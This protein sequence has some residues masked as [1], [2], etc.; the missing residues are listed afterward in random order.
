MAGFLADL[1]LRFLVGFVYFVINALILRE[2][3]VRLFKIAD[4]TFE[5]P[6]V[7][8][9]AISF[10]VILFSYFSYLVLLSWLLMVLINLA[11]IA[12]VRK[13]YNLLWSNAIHIWGVWFIINIFIGFLVVLIF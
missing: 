3:V 6:T 10:F 9:A 1:G 8:A 5:K 7:I 12:W 11:F 4:D 2:I 13:L